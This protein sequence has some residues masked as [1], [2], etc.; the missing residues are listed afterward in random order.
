MIYIVNLNFI[1]Y[2]LPAKYKNGIVS[3]FSLWIMFVLLICTITIRVYKDKNEDIRNMLL[4]VFGFLAGINVLIIFATSEQMLNYRL[5]IFVPIWGSFFGL[6]AV[7]VSYVF[8]WIISK[9]QAV[10]K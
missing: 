6:I 9:A 1:A 2:L 3:I 7:I 8:Y 5:L 10:K 4:F